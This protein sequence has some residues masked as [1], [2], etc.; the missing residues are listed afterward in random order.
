MTIAVVIKLEVVNVGDD[1]RYLF[2]VPSGLLPGF[3][4][5]FVKRTAI[6]QSRQAIRSCQPREFQVFTENLPCITLKEI[7]RISSD[8]VGKAKKQYAVADLVDGRAE[9]DAKTYVDDKYWPSN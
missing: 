9:S 4:Q 8:Q 1:Y 5:M 3:A 6:K 2:V 7:A